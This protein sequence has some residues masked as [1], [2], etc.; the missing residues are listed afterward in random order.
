MNFR[1]W[2]VHNGYIYRLDGSVLEVDN[3]E[4]IN[5]FYNDY[6]SLNIKIIDQYEL[7]LDI[8]YEDL[9]IFDDIIK[10]IPMDK[11]QLIVD[12][13]GIIVENSKSKKEYVFDMDKVNK[14]ITLSVEYILSDLKEKHI[15]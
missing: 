14:F 9:P 13:A 6:T 10:E 11:I 5:F 7:K 1:L 12:K 8:F 3:N 4:N 2:V 15:Y